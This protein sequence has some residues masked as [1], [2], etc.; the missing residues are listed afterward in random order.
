MT[1]YHFA[2]IWKISWLAG[3]LGVVSNQPEQAVELSLWIPIRWQFHDGTH[4]WESKRIALA[5]MSECVLHKQQSLCIVIVKK[6]RA[7]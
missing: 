2:A 5:F 4:V 1:T 6:Y 7:F 3:P